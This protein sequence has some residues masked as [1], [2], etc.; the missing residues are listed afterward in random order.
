[1]AGLPGGILG[2][3]RLPGVGPKTAG[4]L[5]RELGVTSVEGLV[6]A[7]EDGR[8]ADLPGMGE[9]TVEKILRHARLTA[10]VSSSG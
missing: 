2:L 9:R 3:M 5:W 4:R 1:M 10:Q 7:I 6:E 8:V